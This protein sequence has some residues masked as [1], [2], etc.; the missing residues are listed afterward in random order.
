MGSLQF[1][2][3]IMV[4]GLYGTQYSLHEESWRK[5]IVFVFVLIF[6]LV[7]LLDRGMDV[8]LI[9]LACFFVA[10]GR[11]VKKAM[12]FSLYFNK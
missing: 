1:L 7:V 8:L 12:C 2:P 9:C 5:G 3:G 6:F 11:Y 10:V 4:R